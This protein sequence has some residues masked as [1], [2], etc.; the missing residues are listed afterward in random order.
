[1]LATALAP[2]IGYDKA[3][4]IAK[5]AYEQN[6]TIKEVALE[7]TS[8]SAEQLDDILNPAHMVRL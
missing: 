2:H 6:R 5:T 1:M 8:L 3:A 7:K 4:E